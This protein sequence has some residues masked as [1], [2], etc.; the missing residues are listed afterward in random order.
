MAAPK[1]TDDVLDCLTQSLQGTYMSSDTVPQ[2]VRELLWN[3]A[4]TY[5]LADSTEERR[6][7]LSICATSATLS[8]LHCNGFPGLSAYCYKRARQH[9]SEHG[10]GK[11]L[12]KEKT[13][14]QRR[15]QEAAISDFVDYLLEHSTDSPFGESKLKLSSGQI[16]TVANLIRDVRNENL[17]QVYLEECA[18]NPPSFIPLARTSCLKI[19]KQCKASYR[20]CV[21]GLDNFVYFG[22]EAFKTMEQYVSEIGKLTGNSHWVKEKTRMLHASRLYLKTDF[23]SHLFIESVVPDHCPIFALSDP[24]E[25]RLQSHCSSE[26]KNHCDRQE[27]MKYYYNITSN[28]SSHEAWSEGENLMLEMVLCKPC[29]MMLACVNNSQISWFVF[30]R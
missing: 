23:K 7:I 27:F 15:D 30:C 10:P 29:R 1:D 5:E 11:V 26:H 24:K 6:A 28:I 14:H 21:Q 20:H 19:A 22:G 18:Q 16:I 17:V 25:E 9:A 8:D 3:L 2:R 13:V 12:K 4:E